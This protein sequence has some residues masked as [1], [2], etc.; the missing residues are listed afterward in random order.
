MFA[1]FFGENILKITTSVPAPNITYDCTVDDVAGPQECPRTDELHSEHVAAD[2]GQ[3]PVHVG[4]GEEIYSK[5]W[6]PRFYT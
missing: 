3:V 5:L 2:A 6:T 1:K 4:S